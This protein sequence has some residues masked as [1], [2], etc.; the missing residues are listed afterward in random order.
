MKNQ[1]RITKNFSIRDPKTGRHYTFVKGQIAK[2]KQI[3]FAT[4]ARIN[5]GQF[6][7]EEVQPNDASICR[8]RDGRLNWH[9]ENGTDAKMDM[10]FVALDTLV[11]HFGSD[12]LRCKGSGQNSTFS[13]V[14]SIYMA[15]FKSEI[16][17]EV[18]DGSDDYFAHRS[19]KAWRGVAWANSSDAALRCTAFILNFVL[20]KY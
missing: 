3:E 5:N 20:A 1:I 14:S 6:K 2:G 16:T 17:Y 11:K 7:V 13:S 18:V 12:A 8:R 19:D 15:E 10:E 4:A 9:L